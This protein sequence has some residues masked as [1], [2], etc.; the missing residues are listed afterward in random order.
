[1]NILQKGWGFVVRL[2]RLYSIGG[3]IAL[4]V[5]V[6]LGVHFLTRPAAA[7]STSATI[8][9]VTLAS[10]GSLSGNTGALS[11]VGN[12]SSVSKAS[13]LAETSGEIVSLNHALG[14]RVSAGAIIASFENS[15][16]QAAVLQ[17]Q[18]AYAGAQ[19]ALAKASGSTAANSSVTSAQATQS[20]E[21][22]ALAA[23]SVLHSAYA[24]VDDAIH[25]KADTMMS[26]PRSNTPQ[27]NVTVP[28]SQ[29]VVNIQNERTLLDP[30]ITTVATLDDGA[31][32]AD[33]DARAGTAISSLQTISA[34][35]DD[36]A[37]ALNQAVPSQNVSASMIATDQATIAA[38]RT[39][40]LTS[41]SNLTSAKS[42]YDSAVAGATTATNSASTG[43]A[44]D[45]A[46]AQANL[47]SA[48]GSL[49][50]AEANLEKTIVRAPISGTI[51]SLP[52]TRGGFVAS[53][54]PVAQISN[55]SA[56]EIDTYVTSSDAKT[57]VRGGTATIEGGVKG[58]ITFIAPA[59]DPTTGKIQ[60]KIGVVGDQSALTDG[61]TVA[62]QLVRSESA[63]SATTD[64]TT[65]AITIPI[66]A[67]K[68]TPSGPVVFTVSS[69]TLVANVVTFG[70]ISGSSV[71]ITAG[72]TPDM[73]IVTDARGLSDGEQVVV[74]PAASN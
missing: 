43:T 25:T 56:L 54:S 37:T 14:D 72:I 58:V 6:L 36:M 13:I 7:P 19:A 42:A 20:A 68:I 51:V 8:A 26:N 31:T 44:N 16:Q 62:V 1:M 27:L 39:E 67:A 17:A 40:V 15:S 24:S 28:D 41:I 29:L 64:T 74:D 63:V 66:V 11:V 22:A 10:V 70:A 5:V 48:Q 33:V 34:F 45:I 30:L 12:V 73:D 50:A 21:N 46:A 60:V 57:L 49:N 69:S 4:F 52:I 61:D 71:T 2:P 35:L 53:F 23:S 38:A 55:P 18:G 59:L 9:H 32:S 3:G 47:K 65:T